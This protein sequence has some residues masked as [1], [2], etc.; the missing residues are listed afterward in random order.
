MYDKVNKIFNE[1]FKWE[2]NKEKLNK[3]DI[4]YFIPDFKEQAEQIICP[5][6]LLIPLFP[7]QCKK[8]DVVLCDN[9]MNK[10]KNCPFC[11]EIFEKKLDRSLLKMIEQMKLYCPNSS[12]HLK[13]K[14]CEYKSHILNCEFSDYSCLICKKM[15]KKSKEKCINHAYECGFSD[16]NCIYCSII[17]KLYKKKEHETLCGELEVECDL[18]K[19]KIKNK[20]LKN[21][22]E[23]EMRIIKCEKCLY[24]LTYKEFKIHTIDKCKDNQILYWKN[25]Y[26]KEKMKNE[27]KEKEENQ[28]EEKFN[29]I[30]LESPK[31]NHDYSFDISYRSFPKK[32]TNSLS[33]SFSKQDLLQY[34]NYLKTSPNTNH[35]HNYKLNLLNNHSLNIIEEKPNKEIG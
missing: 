20:N 33:K 5:I 15:I 16:V 28:I 21:H 2:G 6:C 11:R 13:I 22:N 24:E 10:N 35:K 9:C 18:C 14:F 19:L 23:C 29:N 27:E 8:C 25:L 26:L 31:V 1:L 3:I 30:Y 34:N 32:K 4:N 17:I 7:I 12:C